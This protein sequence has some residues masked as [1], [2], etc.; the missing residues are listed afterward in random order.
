M[1]S[2]KVPVFVIAVTC[3]ASS[4]AEAQGPSSR[5]I[6]SGPSIMQSYRDGSRRSESTVVPIPDLFRTEAPFVERNFRIDYLGT[7]SL[8]EPV[9]D[10]S[11][12][13]A[14]LSYSFTER[15]GMIVGVPVL[16]RDNLDE[17]DASGFGDLNAGLRYVA[18]GYENSDPFK[19]ALGLNVLAPTGD[20]GRS[21]GEG[22][23]FIEP[24]VLLFQ[25]LGARTFVQGQFSL[26]IPTA[27]GD[28]S[29][30]F[31]WNLGMGHVFVDFTSSRWFKFPTPILELNGATGLGGEDAGTTVL[32]ITPGLRW[33]I[34]SRAFGGVGMSVPLT[35]SREFD[36]QFIFSLIYRY[37]PAEESAP[38]PT[39]S[40]AYF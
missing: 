26:G 17:P 4:F 36:T 25:K 29:K 13:A 14:E 16:M 40:R 28:A 24:E 1:R 30:E 15:F 3:F 11:E 21:L 33:T 12:F 5:P 35:G 20:A 8:T 19:L 27:G 22:Q 32:D 31:G 34:G 37:G 23:T 10:Q 6:I 9:A 39:S 38:D 7:N 18:L 2:T